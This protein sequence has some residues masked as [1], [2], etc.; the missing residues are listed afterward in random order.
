MPASTQLAITSRPAIA[1][2]FL[3]LRPPAGDEKG[4]D[5]WLLTLSDLL[6]LLL[7]FFVLLFGLSLQPQS[8]STSIPV[9]NATVPAGGTPLPETSSSDAG[10]EEVLASSGADLQ[11]RLGDDQD[12]IA[13]SR[14]ADRL[15]LTFPERI[16]FEPGESRLNA[17]AL[18]ILDKVAGWALDHPSFYLEVQGHTDD[19]PIRSSRYPSNWELSVDRA[20]RVAKTLIEMGINPRLIRIQGFGEFHGLCANDSETN[21]SRNRRVEIQF[22][23]ASMSGETPEASENRERQRI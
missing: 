12:G 14:R 23:L 9:V 5:L 20:T 6:L 10:S 4:Q 13:I 16:V 19:R 18:P 7:I 21:R 2:R 15:V 11:A 1:G 22:F 8:R 17:S 3:L